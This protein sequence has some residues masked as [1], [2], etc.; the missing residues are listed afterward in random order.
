MT[1][2]TPTQAISLALFSAGLTFGVVHTARALETVPRDPHCQPDS[3]PATMQR[4]VDGDTMVLQVALGLGVSRTVTIRLLGIDTPELRLEERPAGLRAKAFVESWSA[5]YE[6]A[7]I[8]RTDGKL[9][10]YGRLLAM[11]CPPDGGECLTEA[12]I[13]GGHVK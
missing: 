4:V 10:K 11:V 3:Y 12:L 9:G 7:V 6:N 5:R 1:Q 13:A 8:L 2:I